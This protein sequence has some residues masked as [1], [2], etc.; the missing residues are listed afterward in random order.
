MSGDPLDKEGSGDTPPPLD[1]EGEKEKTA[2]PVMKDDGSKDSSRSKS[3]ISSGKTLVIECRV[4][5][6]SMKL[7]NYKL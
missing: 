1:N 5:S 3:R 6:K 4:C 7:Q 2:A